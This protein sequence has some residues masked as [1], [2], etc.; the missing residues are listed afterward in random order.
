MKILAIE[1]FS[2]KSPVAAPVVGAVGG[3]VSGSKFEV[4]PV[5]KLKSAA[6]MAIVPV[7]TK[8]KSSEL[9]KLHYT[10]ARAMQAQ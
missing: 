7:A 2:A 6:F 5:G 1:L 3:K 9:V 8:H 4:I 10:V